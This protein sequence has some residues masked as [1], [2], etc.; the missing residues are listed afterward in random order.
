MFYVSDEEEQSQYIKLFKEYGFD[1]VILESSPIDN[2]FVSF[3]E[4]KDQ[5][6]L[7]NRIDAD[8][9]DVLKD[10]KDDENKE[11]KNRYRKLI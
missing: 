10:K 4:Y 3:L 2:N 9:S 6:L 1:A 5:E 7:Y 11:E 8:L